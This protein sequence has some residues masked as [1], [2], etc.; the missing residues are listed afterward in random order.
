VVGGAFPRIRCRGGRRRRSSSSRPRDQQL[1]FGT[2]STSSDQAFRGRAARQ[3]AGPRADCLGL[4]E[5]ALSISSST[6]N[7]S[8]FKVLS[9]RPHRNCRRISPIRPRSC[10]ITASTRWLRMAVARTRRAAAV[11]RPAHPIRSAPRRCARFERAGRSASSLRRSAAIRP[12][13]IVHAP[14]PRDMGPPVGR[15]RVK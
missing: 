9:A 4:S 7:A 12:R 14:R 15:C 2:T 10:W 5:V 6:G 11:A 8:V 3:P 1:R 13:R